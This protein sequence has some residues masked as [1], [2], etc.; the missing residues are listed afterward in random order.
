MW[1]H[2][3]TK[4]AL[5]LEKLHDPSVFRTA[6]ILNLFFCSVCFWDFAGIVVNVL[7]F[8]WA[9]VFFFD[10]FVSRKSP[11]RIRYGSVL[12]AFLGAGLITALLHIDSGF[13]MNLIMLYHAAVCFFLFY[14]LHAEP[15][16]RK[17]KR[18]MNR[19]FGLIMV[20]STALSVGGL[21]I[22]AFA[23]TGR[24]YVSDYILGIMD[25]RFT[26]LYTNPNLA[27]FSSVIGM[28]CCHILLQKRREQTPGERR[29]PVWLAVVCFAG[30]TLSLLLS[31]SNASLVFAITYF[32]VYS[33]YRLYQSSMHHSGKKSVARGLLLAVCC[34][35]LAFSSLAIRSSCQAGVSQL[36]NL[37]TQTQTQK[38]AATDTGSGF[39]PIAAMNVEIGRTEEYEVS[40][41]RLGSLEQ[42]MVLF[43]KFPLMGVGKGNIVPYGERYLVNGFTYTDLHA[44][45]LT[46]LISN[47]LVGLSIFAAFVMLFGRRLIHCLRKNREKN[48]KELP[49]LFAA[50]GAY[51]VYGFFE[52][53][54]LFDVTFMVVIFWLL[55][56]YTASRMTKYE[57]QEAPAAE[58]GLLSLGSSHSPV[59]NVFPLPTQREPVKLRTHDVSSAR[60]SAADSIPSYS[61][62]RQ[63]TARKLS[64]KPAVSDRAPLREHPPSERWNQ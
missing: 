15:N 42:S 6:Y 53:A 10:L 16:R 33:F 34:L 62:Y 2:M 38:T 4:K 64:Q 22:V 23:P 35:T 11:R 13:G 63:S 50:I 48:L 60:F 19:I 43:G 5:F 7:M 61:T 44:G 31:D 37:T 26:G 3:R 30:N 14:G 32:V 56:G 36:I 8:L 40:S 49:M 17:T 54:V 25:N 9:G 51:G 45:Y 52:K 46:I 58:F 29:I 28:V 47:G 57:W 55:L 12:L 24:L 39:S 41:G 27:A 18:E 59:Y 20:L 21:A 1:V